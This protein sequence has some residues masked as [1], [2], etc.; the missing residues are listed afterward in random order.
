[1]PLSVGRVDVEDFLFYEAALLDDWKLNEWLALFEEGAS[2][3]VPPA[4]SDDDVDPAKTLFY[5]ADDW[6]RLKERVKRL[7]KKTA[8]VEYPKSKCRH[9]ISNVRILDGDDDLF[10]VAANF[11]TY[12]SKDGQTETYLGHHLYKMSLKNGKFFIRHKCSYL[13]TDNI[14]DQGKVSIFI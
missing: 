8:H 9:L 5:I 14:N 2:Y 3:W 7:G 12:R 6:F 1:M 11:V 10:R 13:D 4:G